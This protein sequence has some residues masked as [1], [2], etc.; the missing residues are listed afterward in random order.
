MGKDIDQVNERPGNS[1][2]DTSQNGY[3][4]KR[5]EMTNADEDLE[6]KE[7]LYTLGEMFLK[8]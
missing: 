8:I 1:F 5:Q 7:S 6:I 2:K 3:F 4:K